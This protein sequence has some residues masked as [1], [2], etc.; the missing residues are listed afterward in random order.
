MILNTK[1]KMI[2]ETPPVINVT[3]RLYT[4]GATYADAIGIHKLLKPLQIKEM[5]THAIKYHIA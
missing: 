3:R 4:A 2:I 5:S 1:K